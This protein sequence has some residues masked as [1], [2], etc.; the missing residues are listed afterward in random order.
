M[1]TAGYRVVLPHMTAVTAMAELYRA[2]SRVF[3]FHDTDDYIA[4]PKN[5][6]CRSLHLVYK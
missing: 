5:T 6:G 4:H 3:E 1:G 2:A